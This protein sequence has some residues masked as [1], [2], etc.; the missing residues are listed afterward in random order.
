M[1]E[2]REGEAIEQFEYLGLSAANSEQKNAIRQ[3]GREHRRAAFELFADVIA[4][5]GY[6]L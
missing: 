2:S 4:A 3:T 6:R 5:V 1:A